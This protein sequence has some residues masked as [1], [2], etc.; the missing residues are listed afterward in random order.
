M[1]Q[2]VI[3]LIADPANLD[4]TEEQMLEFAKAVPTRDF[5]W[6]EPGVAC[7]FFFALGSG[8]EWQSFNPAYLIRRA[9]G[10]AFNRYASAFTEVPFE[11]EWRRVAAAIGGAPVDF[12]IQPTH[13]RKKKLLV[14]DMD[15][16]LITVECIDELADFVGKKTEVAAITERAMN[17]DLDF[18]AAL[19]ERVALLAGLPEST[20]EQCYNER[21]KLMPGARELV[22]TMKK[23]GAKTVL[24]S[25]GFTFFTS[26]VREALG[27][28]ED[29]SN[30]LEVKDGLLTGKVV[31]PIL[32]KEAKLEKLK[33]VYTHENISR[34][35][36]L[37]VGDG[38]NDI[39]MLKEAGLGVAYRAKPRVQDQAWARI[40]HND[41]SALLYLQGYKKEE[42]AA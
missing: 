24:V 31:P 36:T 14:A 25:G 10:A 1:S 5:G 28:D 32:G 17:G 15:S 12:I 41:L 18:E 42:F 26:R 6:V 27:F 40:N 11:G 39:P 38:A 2:Y 13:G 30:T 9:V 20:L 3:T 35:Y 29:H 19:N 7:D 23:N 8:A 4:L 16:T 37:A 21:V 33:D 34:N 22:Q